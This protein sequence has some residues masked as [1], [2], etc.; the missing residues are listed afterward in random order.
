MFATLVL[1]VVAMAAVMALFT[2]TP[3]LFRRRNVT[4][5][6]PFDIYFEG[7]CIAYIER[8]W[9]AL[10]KYQENYLTERHRVDYL[11]ALIFLCSLIVVLAVDRDPNVEFKAWFKRWLEQ[12]SP[13]QV[14]LYLLL[15][16][17]HFATK[18]QPQLREHTLVELLQRWQ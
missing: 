12:D 17:W 18:K 9:L 11:V 4:T 14:Q 7:L 13:A 2:V 1:T 5:G 16:A 8:C 15:V 6:G 10:I 3:V